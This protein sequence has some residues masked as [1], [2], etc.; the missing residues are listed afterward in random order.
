M[1]SSSRKITIVYSVSAWNKWPDKALTK[2]GE[3]VIQIARAV[4]ETINVVVAHFPSVASIGWMLP[5]CIGCYIY[6]FDIY[7][8]TLELS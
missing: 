5:K 7:T 4:L 3:T 1:R 8:V 6:G 2:M